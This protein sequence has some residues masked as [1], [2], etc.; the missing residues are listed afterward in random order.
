MAGGDS[1]DA[2]ALWVDVAATAVSWYFVER[3]AFCSAVPWLRDA[4]ATSEAL[5]PIMPTRVRA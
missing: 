5:S 3:G 1:G 4:Q 2:A